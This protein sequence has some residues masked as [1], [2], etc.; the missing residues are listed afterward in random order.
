MAVDSTV[1]G[2]LTRREA[3]TRESP[4]YDRIPAE[5]ERLHRFSNSDARMTEV[6]P[7]RDRQRT[8]KPAIEENSS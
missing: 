1:D 7:L 8:A 2:A 4:I 3:A 6:E 5:T